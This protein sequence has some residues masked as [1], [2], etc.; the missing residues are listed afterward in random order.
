MVFLGLKPRK[1]PCG[2]KSSDLT[3][4]VMKDFAESGDLK[5]VSGLVGKMVLVSRLFSQFYFRCRV[6]P[7][8]VFG[9]FGFFER[10][11]CQTKQKRLFWF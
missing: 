7:G 3:L 5:K 4:K 8:L 9:L 6:L 1:F 2:L 11:F 10:M